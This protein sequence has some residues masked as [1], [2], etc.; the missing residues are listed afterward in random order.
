MD[1]S[2]DIC[3]GYMLLGYLPPVHFCDLPAFA[4]MK[5][6]AK[7]KWIINGCIRANVVSM[8]HAKNLL[9]G[10]RALK[11]KMKGDK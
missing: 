4:G 6:N 11:V 3:E 9:R 7:N 2:W 8:Y 1:L 5:L 10:L